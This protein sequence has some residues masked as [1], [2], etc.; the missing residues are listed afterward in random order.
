LILDGAHRDHWRLDL[1][2]AWNN[3]ICALRRYP[4][5]Y[6]IDQ[7][8]LTA[9]YL[10][11]PLIIAGILHMMIVR[12]DLFKTFAIPL[13]LKLFGANKTWRGLLLMPILCA[14]GFIVTEKIF[15]STPDVLNGRNPF[16]LGLALG[17]AY[18][19]GELPNSFFKRRQG[20]LPGKLPEK[21]RLFHFILDHCD[22]ALACCFVY[23]VSLDISM[24]ILAITM[25]IGPLIHTLINI[26]L[27]ACNLRREIF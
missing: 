11:L 5:S 3:Q 21:N 22:S 12:F 13:H 7:I 20:I 15:S 26:A 19:I 17:F 9:F 10:L 4:M 6:T 27:W 14:F 25:I 2:F 1:N 18:I 24:T 8:A 16:L 23:A